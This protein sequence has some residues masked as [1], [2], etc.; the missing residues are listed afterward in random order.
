MRNLRPLSEQVV[1]ITGASSGIG[2]DA[3]LRFAARGARVVLAARDDVALH[4]LA[5]EIRG[6][7][8]N[9]LPV[10]TDVT[11][12][13]QVAR[14]AERAVQ[15]YGG[16]DTW[17]ND[18][19][20]AM[21]GTFEQLAL[22]DLR[23][24]IDVNFWGQVHG[25]RAALPYLKRRGTGAIIFVGS[26][27][28][29]RAIPLQ[30]GYCAAKHAVKALTESLR[31]EL[32]HEGSDIQITL[33]KPASINTPFFDNALTLTGYRPRPVDP[34]YGV[35]VVSDVLLHCAEHRER[36]VAAG[37]AS[38]VI[39]TL[40]AF[41]GPVMDAVLARSGFQGQM[42]D[43]WKS[44]EAPHNLYE[45]LTSDRRTRGPHPERRFSLYT[46]MRLRMNGRVLAAGAG[47]A[48]AALV[49]RR[50]MAHGGA[51]SATPAR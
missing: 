25:A 6:S 14:L 4:D 30:S 22:E 49:L 13:E 12:Y 2:R 17:I 8:G 20:V 36:E 32:Q 35:S 18:A 44:A 40:E 28:S 47:I 29:D 11:D 46:S 15:T 37:G 48:G 34:V 39:C 42:T 1:V 27:L 26:A 50:R 21:Y 24:Q 43:D 23:Q 51:G 38:K 31:T 19:A 9:A 33:V 16:I 41:A 10:A 3:A 5:D 7:G 45:P